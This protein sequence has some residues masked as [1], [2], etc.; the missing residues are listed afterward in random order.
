MD[1]V[2]YIVFIKRLFKQLNRELD[3]KLLETVPQTRN[4][5][6]TSLCTSSLVNKLKSLRRLYMAIFDSFQRTKS[7]TSSAVGT[8][9]MGN[10]LIAIWILGITCLAIIGS[11]TIDV[12][13]YVIFFRL[14]LRV[15]FICV[16]ALVC[17]RIQKLVS[18]LA[19]S[20]IICL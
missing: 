18:I 19:F 6:S 15:A 14:F 11:R 7:F 16:Y 2:T 13:D 5:F 3:Q 8:T 17:D 12:M 20:I 9:V 4:I 10:F 1:T